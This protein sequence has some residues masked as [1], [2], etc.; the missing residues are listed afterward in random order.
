MTQDDLAAVLAPKAAG[1]WNLH[2]QT[3]G[4]PLDCFV[5]FS[6]I[7]VA[8]RRAWS[9]QLRGGQRRFSMRSPTIAGRR[10]CPALSVN[11]GQLADVGVAAEHGRR[12]AGISTASASR[13][14]PCRGRARRRSPRLIVCGEAQ[15]GA[16]DVDW[17]RLGR[18]SAKFRTSPV[19]RDLA[20]S[21]APAGLRHEGA[22]SWREAVLSLPAEERLAAVSDMVASQIAA[23]LGM[24]PSD[25]DR[26]GPLSGM[27][28]LMAVELKVADREPL[29]LR[30][31]HRRYQ[32][33]R[34]RRAPG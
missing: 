31:P 17:A 18:A 34:H 29:G 12:S 4:L 26:S 15:V 22:A 28:S 6:S 2:Q 30:T 14:C 32:R 9:G 16:M 7:S 11:W 3:R 1:A 5:M 33:G 10:D 21:A 20:Q 24:P 25:V 19:F 8:D 27:D 13:H 23:T